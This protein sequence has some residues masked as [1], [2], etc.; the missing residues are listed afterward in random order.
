MQWQFCIFWTHEGYHRLLPQNNFLSACH[1]SIMN[2]RSFKVA[3]HSTLIMIMP[4]NVLFQNNEFMH[5]YPTL[6]SSDHA[7]LTSYFLKAISQ[8]F[9]D[10]FLSY[11]VQLGT[12]P[13][14]IQKSKQKELC[15]TNTRRSFGE[16]N[17]KEHFSR[18]VCHA[19]S[20]TH[21]QEF[22]AMV[23]TNW[24]WIGP[25]IFLWLPVES[26]VG[27]GFISLSTI[28]WY[29]ALKLNGSTV[30]GNVPVNIAYM[31]TP[32]KENIQ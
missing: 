4:R 8:I 18:L 23:P 6:K 30:K 2:V 29:K 15:Y 9:T 28:F 20:M 11:S 16:Q 14:Y 17:E 1:Y 13:A 19:G 7:K 21:N 5:P 24:I 22:N 25:S 26:W 27:K 12:S 31:F 32:L 10:L 3:Y